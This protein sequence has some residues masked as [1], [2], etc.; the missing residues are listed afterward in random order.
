LNPI[1]ADFKG[2]IDVFVLELNPAGNAFIYS[3]YLGG[4]ALDYSTGVAVDANGN[5]YVSG[6]TG[7]ANFPVFN[8]T[9]PRL[10]G[11]LN[12]FAAKIAP[13]GTSLVY[14]T[15][16]GGSSVDFSNGMAIDRNG[17]IVIVGD[18]SS[19]NIPTLNAF[20]PTFC[21]W[22][23][24]QTV[25]NNHGFAAMLNPSGVPVFA[26]YVCGT[27]AGD[28]VRAAVFDTSGNVILTGETSSLAFPTLNPIQAAYGGGV[29]DSYVMKLTTNGTLLYSTYLGGNGEDQGRSIALDQVGNV[30][31]T[32]ETFSTN[33]PTMNPTQI[34]NG[35]GADVFLTKINAAGTAIDFSTY[36]G[37]SGADYGYGIVVDGQANA[38]VTGSTNSTNF[39]IASSYQH[40]Y[41]G[42]AND[43]FLTVVST[44]AFA[45]ST[46]SAFGAPG[47]TG[48]VT[49]TTTPEC[50]W[51]ATSNNP[52]IT[53]TS[54]PDSGTG[55]GSVAY[56]VAPNNGTSRTGSLT[57]AGRTVTITQSAG[58]VL[59]IVS[60]HTGNF[61]Q[62]Q[63]GAVYTLTV[64]NAAT[65]VATSG[66]VTVTDTLPSGLILTTMSGTGWT[67]TASTCM[68]SDVLAAGSS[69]PSIAVSVAVAANA[70]SPLINQASV[71]GGGAASV[72]T[73]TDSTTIIALP[74]LSI[75]STHTGSFVQGQTGS[76]T[77]T[78]SNSA[79]AGATSGTVSV[80][81]TLPSGL[82]LTTMSGTA[83]ACTAN[84]CTR[85][86]VLAPGSSYPSIA[87]S[88]AV[89]AN[90]AS[91]LNNQATVSGGGAAS[92]ATA[93]DSTTI[94]ASPVLSITSTH[95]GSF[96]QGQTGSYTVTVSN[97][98]AAG[99]TSGTVTVTEALPVGLTLN[100]MSGTG[101]TC[102]ANSCTRG[103]VLAAGSSYPLIAVS[104]AV[105]ANATS[106]LNN[107]ATV[108]GGGA[109]SAA[110]ATDSTTI[111]ASAVLSITST[112]TGSFVQG[113]TGSYTV[114][115]SNSAAAGPSNGTVTVTE[116][117]P[118]GLTL[119]TM[120]GTGWTCSAT[121]CT[122]SDVLAP[123]ASYP[124]IAVSV[125]VA[126]NAISP[127]INQV[128]VSGGGASTAATGT[129]STTIGSSPL[130][131][132]TS[133]HSGNF[134]QGQLGAVYTVTVSNA[135]AASPTN[136]TVTVTDSLPAGLTLAAISGTGWS[137]PANT[138]T[139]SDVLA[140]GASY[141][142]ITVSVNVDPAAAAS[143]TN[144]V[145][146]SGGGAAP[147]TGT[148]V[149]SIQSV[150]TLTLS[151]TGSD[152]L[153]FTGLALS[154]V[155]GTAISQ[156]N[157][158][159]V[160]PALLSVNA[161]C[162]ITVT[163]LP[164]SGNSGDARKAVEAAPQVLLSEGGIA[165]GSR[166]PGSASELRTV[167]LTNAGT[168]ALPIARIAITGS[169]AGDFTQSNTCGT[170]VAAG[171][172]CT[173]S[174]KFQ[175]AAPGNRSAALAVIG[176][177]TGSWSIGLTGSGVAANSFGTSR[178]ATRK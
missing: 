98:A 41:G 25:A 26:T 27:A 64:S 76:Y 48:S 90:A 22:T 69:Y 10:A 158:C 123:A 170:A 17:D 65:A 125:S 96:V 31:V 143:L 60:T 78:V 70:A 163:F 151:N 72:A 21:G 85:S 75:T 46:P 121:S 56:A 152:A 110:T 175:P 129:D 36:I 66:T 2:D 126:S 124:A 160:S 23:T 1:Q 83:W 51:T 154:G 118:V 9:Q 50:A 68:R 141:P 106:P 156:N 52:W 166:N 13:G 67:C 77:L 133:T 34:S 71:S 150:A 30:Y 7:S 159:P 120:S 111:I 146:V 97:S 135:P 55:P 127:L 131:T 62:G 147:A 100:T 148:D 109:A 102:S 57:I 33:F 177:Q 162:T 19:T 63:N 142:A 58:A 173:I 47:G 84:T 112:H 35:G 174:V 94:I 137:C 15:Y 140:P 93:T 171:A 53:V 80:T 61:T 12:N 88:V 5:T 119:N 82:T 43:A 153:S 161:T 169:N 139:R 149:T 24:G 101:W 145:S 59:T 11:Q 99:P 4:T 116:A 45:F 104:V 113:Q 3:T 44:C 114:T 132:I 165:F 86:D 40:S 18:T 87:V 95:T 144:Q 115:V 168:E 103:D 107:Q 164:P 81:E 136:G 74:V 105:A 49:I 178:P 79:A 28:T 138:C 128:T 6:A 117:L 32:G 16:F 39:P 130:L 134:T 38:Y 167:T 108:S 37:G 172:Q 155:N 8:A 89:T 20:E 42:G 92:A 176:G 91:P 14:S 54:S 157:N 122:R 73:A 29:T